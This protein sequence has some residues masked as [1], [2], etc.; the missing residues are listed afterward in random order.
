[1]IKA[2][3]LKA[4]SNN[5]DIAMFAPLVGDQRPLAIRPIAWQAKH[6]LSHDGYVIDMPDAAEDKLRE[7]AAKAGCTL[8]DVEK[9]QTI[10][11]ALSRVGLLIVEE[12]ATEPP[13]ATT[14]PSGN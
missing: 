4:K 13:D 12:Q 1:M 10:D 14:E 2:I 8:V 7:A 11:E 5:N 3:L 6:P 9:R